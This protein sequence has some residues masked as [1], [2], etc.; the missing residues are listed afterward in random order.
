MF[1]IGQR[2]EH[3][4]MRSRSTMFEASNGVGNKL[5]VTCSW[6]ANEANSRIHYGIGGQWQF[7]GHS[8]KRPAWPGKRSRVEDQ[9][10]MRPQMLV[11]NFEVLQLVVADIYDAG[12]GVA[13]EQTRRLAQV[14]RSYGRLNHNEL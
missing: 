2:H 4:A 11:G 13:L 14:T 1:L 3:N 8:D 9:A 5:H 12:G 10:P 7:S 6:T